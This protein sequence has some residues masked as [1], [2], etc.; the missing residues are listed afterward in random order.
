MT[1]S[2]YSAVPLE[3][4]GEERYPF[5]GI[6]PRTALG[7]F[8]LAWAALNVLLALLP[9][10]DVLGNSAEIGPLGM[11]VTVLYSYAAFSLNSVLGVAYYLSRGRAWTR[12]VERSLRG[13]VK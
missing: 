8:F 5:L 1:T 6:V 9:V 13:S 10:F 7:R 2:S 3:R 12:I 11:P 4:D